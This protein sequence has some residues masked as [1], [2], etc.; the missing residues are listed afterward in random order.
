MKL[1]T[2]AGGLWLIEFPQIDYCINAVV[3]LQEYY[4]IIKVEL[5][6]KHK[7]EN[8]TNLFLQLF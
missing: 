3:F 4:I 6:G 7:K 8:T 2:G 1:L 5:H